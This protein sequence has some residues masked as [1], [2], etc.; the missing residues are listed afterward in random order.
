MHEVWYEASTVHFPKLIVLTTMCLH[1]HT[2][3][4]LCYP[5]P[6]LHK[7]LYMVALKWRGH[8]ENILTLNHKQGQL[9]FKKTVYPIQAE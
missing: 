3:K 6:V 2:K 5:F 8:D 1:T 9:P 7:G 4:P